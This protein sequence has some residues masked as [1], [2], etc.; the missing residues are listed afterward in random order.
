MLK[1]TGAVLILLCCGWFGYS[2]AAGYKKEEHTLRQLSSVLDYMECE[3][4]YR[5]T[6]LPELCGQVSA[7]SRGVISKVFRLLQ[8]ELEDQVAPDASACMKAILLKSDG[9]PSLSRDILDSFGQTLGRF[10]LAGQLEGLREAHRSCIVKL[11]DL[12]Q[13]RESRLRSYQTIGICAGA[14]LVVLFI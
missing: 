2:M 7:L 11:D 9:I 12:R 14:A 4:Q 6:P 13:G 3:L 1:L 10:D 8:Q 5:L